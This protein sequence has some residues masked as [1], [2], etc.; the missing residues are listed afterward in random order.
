MYD[1]DFAGAEDRIRPR[2]EGS[3]LPG[4]ELT[5]GERQRTIE[6]IRRRPRIG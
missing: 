4:A 1:E 2:R 3:N 5:D 6:E